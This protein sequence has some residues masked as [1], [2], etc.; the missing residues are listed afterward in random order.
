MGERDGDFTDVSAVV[1][2]KA[3]LGEIKTI[4]ITFDYAPA[5]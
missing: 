2:D 3:T 1:L 4:T 5:E